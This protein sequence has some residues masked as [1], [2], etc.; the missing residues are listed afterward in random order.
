[1]RLTPHFTVEELTVSETA[2]RHGIS[3]DPGPA[4]LANLLRLAVLLEDARTVLGDHAVLV[5]SGFRAPGVN[6]LVGG[7][8]N[9]DH[10]GGRAADF[11]CPGFGSPLLVCTAIVKAREIEFD[12]LIMEGTWTHISVPADGMA[13]RREV[14]T[15]H[16]GARGTT[17]TKGLP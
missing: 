10:M 1:M 12:R 14:L 13:A 16:F 9:S 7:A 3:N 15:A 8:A 11:I 6:R 4:E 5:T 17:Y 2:A